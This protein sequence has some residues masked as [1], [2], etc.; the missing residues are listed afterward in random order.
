MVVKPGFSP[1]EL[2][3]LYPAIMCVQKTRRR[4]RAMSP[5]RTVAK[6]HRQ[7]TVLKQSVLVKR[8]RAVLLLRPLPS[9]RWRHTINRLA[10]GFDI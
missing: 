8:N 3:L 9:F 5:K 2:P 4:M 1:D 6:P 10:L 7:A